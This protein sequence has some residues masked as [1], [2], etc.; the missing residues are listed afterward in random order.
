MFSTLLISSEQFLLNLFLIVPFLF[1]FFKFHYKLTSS[2]VS[3]IVSCSLFWS[4]VHG[5]SLAPSSLLI[6]TNSKFVQ[7][8]EGLSSSSRGESRACQPWNFLYATQGLYHF[9]QMANCKVSYFSGY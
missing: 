4:G 6:S 8:A 1:L 7:F 2:T 9:H 5:I 3:S